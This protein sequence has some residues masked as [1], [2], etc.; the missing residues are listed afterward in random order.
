MRVEIKIL[1]LFFKSRNL[2]VEHLHN[3]HGALGSLPGPKRN[4]P[5]GHVSKGNHYLRIYFP[6]LSLRTRGGNVARAMGAASGRQCCKMSAACVDHPS[7]SGVCLQR[8]RKQNHREGLLGRTPQLRSLAP[9]L[10]ST[11]D[12]PCPS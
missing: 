2:E 10:L 7:S 9:H 6:F 3:M 8:S 4:N 12:N 1:N 11:T 5:P